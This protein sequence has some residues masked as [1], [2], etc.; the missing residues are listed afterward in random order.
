MDL[1][2]SPDS[3]PAGVPLGDLVNP[4]GIRSAVRRLFTGGLDEILGELFQNS[5]RAGARQVDISHTPTGWTY[6]DDGHGV[7]G[8]A[9][10]HTLLRLADSHFA[11]P[12]V[13]A[14]QQPMG[15]GLHAL[16]A[17]EGITAVTFRSGG[18]RL[19]VDTARWWADPAYYTRWADRLAGDLE[20]PH[21]L[22]IEVTCT[23]AV[24][25]ALSRALQAD[26]DGT[27]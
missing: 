9:G 11:N 26:Y 23:P 4:H 5:Q 18:L 14:D 8:V 24:G 25:E 2:L 13:A 22:H 15:L 3:A 17:H 10:F 1:H 16:L 12:L 6:T 19:T 21:G 7:A 27:S 20:P